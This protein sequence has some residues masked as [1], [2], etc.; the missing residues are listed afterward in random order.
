MSAKR[1][2]IWCVTQ[3]K[4]VYAYRSDGQKPTTCPEDTN[5]TI[6]PTSIIDVTE[7][8][9]VQTV[10][11]KEED[12]A[13]GGRFASDTMELLIPKNETVKI[14]KSWPFPVSILG[15]NFNTIKNN[16]GD[17]LTVRI[18][19]DTIIGA[20][21]APVFPAQSWMETNYVQGNIVTIVH[22]VYG[23]RVYTCIQNTVNNI[24]PLHPYGVQ[25]WK[26]GF[27]VIVSPTV[28]QYAFVGSYIKLCNG[29]MNIPQMGRIISMDPTHSAIY[30]EKNAPQ[31]LSPL[32]P[33][34]VRISVC[35]LNN[36][37]IG[38]EGLYVIGQSKIGGSYV[39]ADLPINIYYTNK[40]STEN[41]AFYGAVE[42]LY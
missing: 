19:E 22:P 11:I 1:Y 3:D 38:F 15:V 33:T 30:L 18:G 34:Y 13:T 31:I 17:C 4:Y 16:R 27:Q 41:K 40:S 10:V 8:M 20:I 5:H 37:I 32:S 6:D 25:Y 14:T 23:N 36:F 35:M 28:F 42:Y 39:P 26:H 7:N 21:L 12:I 24:S 2:R 29:D 9:E